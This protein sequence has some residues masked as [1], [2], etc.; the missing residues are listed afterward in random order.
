MFELMFGI[1]T[2][3]R[4]SG[5]RDRF[6]LKFF[7]PAPRPGIRLGEATYNGILRKMR[8]RNIAL[9]SLGSKLTRFETDRV[10]TENASFEA[11]L[12]LFMPGMTGPAW[13]EGTELPRSA[14]GMIE[15]DEFT[16]VLGHHRVYVVG[17][18]GHY[19]DSP[20]W[21]PKQAHMADLQARAAAANLLLE[22]DDL[23]PEKRFRWELIC[24][25]DT[26]DRGVFVFRNARRMIM[27]PSSRVFHWAKRFFEWQYLRAY[28]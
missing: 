13:I 21:A 3:L 6:E 28:R 12:I 27:L 17:D 2:H 22:L 25:I 15:A 5:R 16:R 8:R 23:Q 19:P 4:R 24:I 10:V 18:S 1:D 26:V 11:D 7:S 14:G 20:D 9:A